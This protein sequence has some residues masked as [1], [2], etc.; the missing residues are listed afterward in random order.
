[1]PASAKVGTSGSAASRCSPVTASARTLPALTCCS[2]D[3]RSSMP[4]GTWP[5]I[6]SSATGPEPR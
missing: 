6:T 5:P 4:S 3:G 2:T 1:M